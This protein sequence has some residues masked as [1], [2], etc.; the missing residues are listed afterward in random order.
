ML[1]EGFKMDFKK[2]IVCITIGVILG[3][4]GATMYFRDRPEMVERR[5]E[6]TQQS[7]G[8][9]SE[10]S[11]GS[12]I[13]AVKTS[14]TPA[15]NGA[16]TS[17]EI[18]I[19]HDPDKSKIDMG[20]C[21]SAELMWL[22]VGKRWVWQMTVYGNSVPEPPSDHPIW[23]YLGNLKPSGTLGGYNRQSIFWKG[24]PCS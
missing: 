7:S 3:V 23:E 20:I 2:I 5:L 16:V 11:T 24:Y 22:E 12:G 10:Q 1:S 21:Y 19:V 4:G 9:Q 15:V 18:R 13:N 17:R 14:K 8:Q 6:L